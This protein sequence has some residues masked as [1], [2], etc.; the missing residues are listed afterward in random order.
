MKDRRRSR[1]G[2]RRSADSLFKEMRRELGTLFWRVEAALNGPMVFD[3]IGFYLAGNFLT[4]EVPAA[5]T[6]R[7]NHR[8]S[9]IPVQQIVVEPEF[10]IDIKIATRLARQIVL[11][12]VFD[13]HYPCH[14]L[15]SA[16]GCLPN[17]I[18]VSALVSELLLIRPSR[19]RL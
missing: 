19:S 5:D 15:V 3:E 10:R 14:I 17:S 2:P 13:N 7:K 9:I 4:A 18:P 8:G 6:V 11:I 12:V 1:N 16:E